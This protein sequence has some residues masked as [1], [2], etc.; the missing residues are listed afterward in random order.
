M[1][2]LWLA[3]SLSLHVLIEIVSA[4]HD[5]RGT[6]SIIWWAGQLFSLP[7]IEATK[8]FAGFGIEAAHPTGY[9]IITLAIAF[10]AWLLTNPPLPG[11]SP[12]G[13]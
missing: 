4:E 3:S 10:G 1:I 12:A 13:L 7:V 9:I 6:L 11:G 5:S 8:M 2:W